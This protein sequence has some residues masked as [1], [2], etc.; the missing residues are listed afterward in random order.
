MFRIYEIHPGISL[1]TSC[2]DN[3]IKFELMQFDVENSFN[4][5]ADAIGYIKSN[6]NLQI[7]IPKDLKAEYKNLCSI[8]C[9]PQMD[10]SCIYYAVVNDEPRESKL[11]LPMV[12]VTDDNMQTVFRVCVSSG[13]HELTT[14][15]HAIL[16]KLGLN[17]LQF[18]AGYPNNIKTTLR[19]TMA[20]MHFNLLVLEAKLGGVE[21]HFQKLVKS[22]Q[23][24]IDELN[25]IQSDTNGEI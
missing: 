25:R 18:M 20:Y 10:G 2:W 21:E 16:Y 11:V 23:Y 15:F 14:G 5:E 6:I 12:T 13:M 22:S 8:H 3:C 9:V 19:A 4:S 1:D 7:E 17:L 24:Y